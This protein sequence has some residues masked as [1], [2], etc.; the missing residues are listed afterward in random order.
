[1]PDQFESFNLQAKTVQQ[2]PLL[3]QSDLEDRF[4]QIDY[5][6]R[7]G[8][9]AVLQTTHFIEDNL[10]YRL[11]EIAAGRLK[12]KIYRGRFVRSRRQAGQGVV[13][14]AQNQ[15]I[16]GIGFD[17]FKLSRTQR[18]VAV[19][20]VARVLRSLRLQ[21]LTYEQILRAFLTTTK[22][23]CALCEELTA[24]QQEL[25]K[26]ERDGATDLIERMQHISQLIDDKQKLESRV[27]CADVN[28]LYGTVALLQHYVTAIDR[29]QNEV[30]RAYLRAIPRIVREYAISDL[31]ALDLFQAGSFGLMHAVKIYDYRA[32]AGFIRVA[33]QWIRERIGKAHEASSGPIIQISSVVY[34]NARKVKNARKQLEQKNPERDATTEEIA[35]LLGWTPERVR[36]I[37]SDIDLAQI[38]SLDDEQ[39]VEMEC[40][41]RV[42]TIPDE[43]EQEAELL[44]QHRQHVGDLV[45]YLAPEDRRLICLHYGCIDMIQNDAID[46]EQRLEEMFRQLACKTL[47]HEYM[48][49]QLSSLYRP[50][51]PT[52][53]ED[54]A[55]E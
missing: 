5:L 50:I 49:G 15:K 14:G 26:A 38:I 53:Q 35:E 6:L 11:A 8:V 29:I 20:L 37:E 52:N 40:T 44:D 33:R 2:Y 7:L 36:Q 19:P 41:A 18:E 16:L 43:R 3:E 48:A 45:Q 25:V 46:P 22:Q 39:T 9:R 51:E 21:N 32:Q 1:M 12:S 31:D 13:V 17:L 23:Y 24:R 34:K 27:G 4:R 42:D 55:D 30:V 47:L 54:D 28:S 10:C